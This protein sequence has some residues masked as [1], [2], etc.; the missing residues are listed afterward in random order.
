MDAVLDFKLFIEQTIYEQSV[1]QP[2]YWE[3]EGSDQEDSNNQV[4]ISMDPAVLGSTF[5][6]WQQQRIP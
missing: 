3:L 1:Q 2:T 6:G 5:C 4:A